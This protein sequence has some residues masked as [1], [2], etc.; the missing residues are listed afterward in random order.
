MGMAACKI[1]P[2][3]ILIILVIRAHANT[4]AMRPRM[5]LCISHLL[6][7]QMMYHAMKTLAG[8]HVDSTGTAQAGTVFFVCSG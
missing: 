6:G 7:R 3:V 5:R 2:T 1:K 4:L 8:P